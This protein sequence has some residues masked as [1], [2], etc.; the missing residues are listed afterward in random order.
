VIRASLE[1]TQVPSRFAGGSGDTVTVLTS[2]VLA[3]PQVTDVATEMNFL[4][5]LTA[6]P[7]ATLRLKSGVGAPRTVEIVNLVR[8]WRVV[9][10]DKA[11]R[12]IV[13]SAAQEGSSP[14]ELNFYSSDAPEDVRPRLR[15]TYV[16]RR[17]FGIP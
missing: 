17:G 8:A 12:A 9:G 4:A 2:T 15:L 10:A 7:V 16:P 13:L 3:R 6:F 14:A 11:T 5:P 1:L